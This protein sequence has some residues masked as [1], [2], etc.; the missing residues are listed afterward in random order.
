MFEVEIKAYLEEIASMETQLQQ[1]G[2]VFQKSIRQ[3]DTYFQHPIRNFAQTDEALRIRNS[4][5][6]SY[7]TY[8]GPKLDSTSKTREEL[9]IEIQ[10]P[11]KFSN[12]LKKLGFSSVLTVAKTR[13]IYS[14]DDITISLD[15]VDDLGDFI[16]LET[17]VS[18]KEAIPS[19]RGRLFTL[20]KQ[21]DI[22]KEKS[23][24]RSYLEL[25]F[26]K[27]LGKL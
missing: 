3:S 10:K 8:K 9:E 2:A 14:L 15:N 17:D 23:E 4:D 22:P 20:L 25:R 27:L 12:I 7:L 21:L 19:A 5:N 26:L 6:Q 13:K 18:D 16:E 24:R 1:L 11:E